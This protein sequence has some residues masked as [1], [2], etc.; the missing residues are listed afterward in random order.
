MTL[1]KDTYDRLVASSEPIHLRLPLEEMAKE[2]RRRNWRGFCDK[3][4][5]ILLVLR[6]QRL[7]LL[8][9][10]QYDYMS[11]LLGM[12]LKTAASPGFQIED[13]DETLFTLNSVITNLLAVTPHRNADASL[14][15]VI[16]QPD[17]LAKLLLLYTPRSG[18]ELP[19][20]KFFTVN[21]MLTSLWYSCVWNWADT[22]VS[23]HVHEK[24][25]R[26]I[27]F[28][29]PAFEP[30]DS[31]LICGYFRCTYV[32]DLRDREVKRVFMHGIRQFTSQIRVNNNPNPKSIAV[33]SAFWNGEHAVYRAFAPFFEEIAKNYD[34]TL[35]HLDQDMAGR[36][37]PVNEFFK[38]VKRV[39]ADPFAIDLS[40][41]ANN[42]FQLV[43]YPDVGM[44]QESMYMSSIRLAP[45]QCMGTGHPA[46]S[47]SPVMDYFISGGE[48]ESPDHP[49]NNYD[50]RLVLLPG[51]SVQPAKPNYTAKFPVIPGKFIINCPW[52]Q[53]KMNYPA[54]R[55][56][57]KILDK[58]ER[59]IEFAF[60]PGSLFTL[61]L[62][63]M[64]TYQDLAETLPQDSYVV[65]ETYSYERYMT[66]LELGRFTMHSYPFGGGTTA[67]D[68]FIMR[69][70]LLVRRGIHEYNRFSAALLHR[71]GL[72]ELIADTDDAWV[73]TAVKLINSPEYFNGIS[74]R[75]REIDL[76]KV[77]FRLEDSDML[78]R[79]FDELIRNRETLA[80]D[81][82]RKPIAIA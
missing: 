55:L 41:V 8:T 27:D 35:I 24:C 52:M 23:P 11:E 70:P 12:W 7:Q 82:S 6:E 68:A 38:S 77:L 3:W 21:P 32:D 25:R 73:D 69:K 62:S 59:P 34:I 63:H 17:N 36:K 56:L 78:R 58:A 40:E 30:I 61:N 43:Y 44:S 53:M 74:A 57:K 75:I 26:F 2:V 29:N 54:I 10:E 31:D 16:D 79:A 72:D 33:V 50:E 14:K 60:F 42:D 80:T 51:L 45:I 18:Y 64:A 19:I 81:K 15:A 48:C 47:S 49:E 5:A 37:P 4:K 13:G 1:F 66:S 20:D 46:S 67:V 9:R 22:Y 76:D 39:K 65:H 28:A 71:M